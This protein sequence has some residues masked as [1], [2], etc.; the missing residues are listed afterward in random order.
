MRRRPAP[1]AVG[2]VSEYAVDDW[3]GVLVD[4]AD[5]E[6]VVAAV[7]SLAGDPERLEKLRAAGVE[8]AQVLHR[9]PRRDQPV[10]VLRGA[11]S[12]RWREAR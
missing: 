3:N 5:E 7:T 9:D 2:G 11:G 8:A 1:A 12:R 10:R 4:T 6:A